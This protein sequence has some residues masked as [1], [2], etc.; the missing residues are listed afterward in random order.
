[1]AK[2]FEN[3]SV[4]FLRDVHVALKHLTDNASADV[5]QPGEVQKLTEEDQRTL[6]LFLTIITPKP[7]KVAKPKPVAKTVKYA[8]TFVPS[9][10]KG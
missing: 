7:E 2:T 4:P 1:M 3:F 9:K 5:V 10:A 6:T 8:K